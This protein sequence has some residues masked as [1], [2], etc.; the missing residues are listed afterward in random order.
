[1]QDLMNDRAVDDLNNNLAYNIGTRALYG[2]SFADFVADFEVAECK[3]YSE[4]QVKSKLNS[5]KDFI[6]IFSL[7]CRSLYANANQIGDMIDSINESNLNIS[8]IT[9]QEVWYRNTDLLF[10]GFK[11][12]YNK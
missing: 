9:L 10:D 3:Y 11:L 4:A 8:V 1:M 6:S 7:N 12:F 5:M 2:N